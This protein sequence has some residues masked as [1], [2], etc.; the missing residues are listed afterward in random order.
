MAVT[1]YLRGTGTA[2][3]P[4]LIHNLAAWDAFLSNTTP[5]FTTSATFEVVSDIDCGGKTYPSRTDEVKATLKGNGHTISNFTCA[6]TLWHCAMGS[7]SGRLINIHISARW[8][9]FGSFGAS[10]GGGFREITNVKL[11]VVSGAPFQYSDVMTG[12]N[13]AAYVNNLVIDVVSGL[14]FYMDR[15]AMHASVYLIFHTDTYP[16]GYSGAT[17][18]AGSN[19][20]NPINYPT[21]D[22]AMWLKDG[23]ATPALISNGR[24]DLTQKFAIKGKTSVGG[25]GKKRVVSIFIAAYMGFVKRQNTDGFGNFLIDIGDI[26]DP[27]VVVH[28]DD[29]GSPFEASKSY[30]LGDVIHPKVP[31]GFAYDCTKAGISGTDD[32]TSWPTSGGLATGAAIFTPRPIYKPESHLVQPVKIDLLTGQPV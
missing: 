29:Y 20:S 9:T 26:Y 11:T 7:Y 31:N 2:A 32:P 10:N 15:T 13:S 6:N 22:S 3:D 21:L 14:P 5:C 8:G 18:L 30:V 17:K 23:I 24:A 19:I 27:V 16:S 1:D 12:K 28:Y 25:V 4:Y